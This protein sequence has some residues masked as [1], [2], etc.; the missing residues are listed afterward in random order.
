MG[1]Y[2]VAVIRCK[3]CNLE[4]DVGPVCAGPSALKDFAL[5]T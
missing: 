4:Q 1:R 3:V 2:N 5:L